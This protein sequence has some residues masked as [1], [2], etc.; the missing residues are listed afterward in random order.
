[1]EKQSNFA[2]RIERLRK[3]AFALKDAAEVVL[4]EVQHMEAAAV[5]FKERVDRKES[6]RTTTRR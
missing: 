4:S 5:R 2:E 1:M 6:P 3:T